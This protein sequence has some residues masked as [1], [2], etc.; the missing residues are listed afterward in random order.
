[1]GGLKSPGSNLVKE[2]VQKQFGAQIYYKNNLV[3]INV[4]LAKKLDKTSLIEKKF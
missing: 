2:I 3:V 4:F 1:M